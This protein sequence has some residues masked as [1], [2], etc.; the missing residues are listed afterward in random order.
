MTI[1]TGTGLVQGGVAGVCVKV[2]ELEDARS[3]LHETNC[4]DRSLIHEL[5]LNNRQLQLTDAA[6]RDR[7]TTD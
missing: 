7:L 5:T 6:L 3:D 2:T 4:K 1:V